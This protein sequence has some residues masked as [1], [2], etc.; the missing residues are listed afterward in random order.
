MKGADDRRVS[1][2]AGVPAGDWG[3]RLVYVDDVGAE[4]GEAAAKGE[5]TLGKGREV[6]DG[7]VGAD[8]DRPAQAPHVVGK[9]SDPRLGA[10]KGSG[11]PI[12]GVER[13]HH[14]QVVAAL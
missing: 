14:G 4:L 10:V 9:R 11:E 8:S 13:R 12:R 3:D 6:R 2:G 1:I 5:D 7:P